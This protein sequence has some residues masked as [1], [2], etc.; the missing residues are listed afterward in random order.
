MAVFPKD[1]APTP[2][3]FAERFF[4][5]QGWTKMPKGGHSAALEQPVL[6][7]ADIRQ[8]ATQF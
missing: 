7:A 2:R 3:E 6:L 5:I 8:F 1:I 4:N